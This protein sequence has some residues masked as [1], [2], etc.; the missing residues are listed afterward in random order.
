MKFT[1][2]LAVASAASV[3]IAAPITEHREQHRKQEPAAGPMGS[4]VSAPLPPSSAATSITFLTDEVVFSSPKYLPKGNDSYT[5]KSANVSSGHGKLEARD[6]NFASPWTS[7]KSRFFNQTE[8]RLTMKDKHWYLSGMSG[9]G[10]F[11][12]LNVSGLPFITHGH[13]ERHDLH[14]RDA[15]KSSNKSTKSYPE[16]RPNA[17]NVSSVAHEHPGHHDLETP[18]DK[19]ASGKSAKD[20]WAEYFNPILRVKESIRYSNERHGKHDNHGNHSKRDIPVTRPFIP[21]HRLPT[22]TRDRPIHFLEARGSNITVMK[23]PELINEVFDAPG[24]F[25]SPAEL[26]KA[27]SNLI[28]GAHYSP[29]PS[30]RPRYTEEGLPLFN[31]TITV[32]CILNNRW[33]RPLCSY[34]DYDRDSNKTEKGIFSIPLV[35]PPV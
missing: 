12:R 26:Q 8:T 34:A 3:G 7:S 10:N 13:P 2:A 16:Q 24:K 11:V 23:H 18:G 32:Q 21:E 27:Y 31:H 9:Y 30:F 20:F 17:S 19:E 29:L 33:E 5:T 14:A 28:S 1:Q 22:H 4:T 35:L 25:I 15:M 6:A